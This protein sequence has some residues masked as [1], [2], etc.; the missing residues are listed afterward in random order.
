MLWMSRGCNSGGGARVIRSRK[1]AAMKLDSDGAELVAGALD[2]GA[3]C[4]VEAAL[5]ALPTD[6]PGV[7]IRD[8]FELQPLLGATGAI[9]RVA[10]HFLGSHW[11]S[12][13]W[14]YDFT[15]FE[16]LANVAPLGTQG[17]C[18]TGPRAPLR[19][20]VFGWRPHRLSR[21]ARGSPPGRRR[22]RSRSRRMRF[23]PG[24]SR[25]RLFVSWFARASAG[26]VSGSE[27]RMCSGGRR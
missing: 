16:G 9:G 26:P 8:Q 22:S 15:A 1:N 4:A 21:L 6:R 24:R 11:T 5:R 2:E 19:L 18:L 23:R 13:L 10:A 27:F 14:T 3:L 17:Q 12:C 7:R 25:M 20:S